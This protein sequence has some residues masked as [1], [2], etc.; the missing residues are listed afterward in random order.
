MIRVIDTL[1]GWI[2]DLFA[3]LG[4]VVVILV[5]AMLVAA[6][7]LLVFKFTSNQE[8]IRRGKAK[9]K[10]GV[11]GVL[12]FRH[13]L[14]RMLREMIGSLLLSL[15]NL[16]FLIVPMLVMIVPLW[17][18]FVY[19]DLRLGYRPLRVGESVV[20]RVH[21]VTD[22]VDLRARDG[23]SVTSSGVRIPAL[24]EVDFRIRVDAPGEHVVE[25][26]V[27]DEVQLMRVCA[28][29]PLSLLPPRGEVP[30]GRSQIR[31]LELAYERVT[32]EFLGIEWAWW[33]LLIV[34]MLPALFALRRPFG[35][36][37]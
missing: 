26:H 8:G 31:L 17:V 33:L 32:H 23:L 34:F 3:P 28:T 27:G 10:A 11:L 18:L 15:A 29:P 2:I 30:E 25:V 20:V 37:F 35:V 1:L 22:G 7:S 5:F 24:R 13:D 19:L 6:L 12:L 4:A 36:D 14:R 21:G 16:R 9:M